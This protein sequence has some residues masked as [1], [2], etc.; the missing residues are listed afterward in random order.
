MGIFDGILLCSDWDGTLHTKEGFN[1]KDLKAIRYFKDNG[2]TF[3]ICSGRYLPYLGS[4]FDV[5]CP[6]TYVITLNGAIIIEPKTEA[7]A[8]E[9]FLG[10]GALTILDKLLEADFSSLMI[11]FE[12]AESGQAFTKE[13]YKTARKT[14]QD[15]RIYK[16]ILVGNDISVVRRAKDSL[17]GVDLMGHT[18]VSS[19]PESL[20]LISERNTKGA[21]V[22]RLKK[23]L[24]AR[25]LVTVGDYENDVSMLKAADIGYAMGDAVKGAKMAA[26]RIT[27]P[28]GEGAIAKIISDLEAEFSKSAAK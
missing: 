13:E 23:L 9:G 3:T 10:E 14:I 21:A 2:G 27:L 24:G 4:F 20:E 17:K 22:I 11:Y 26:D 1:E 28:S 12:N 16:C 6:N 15:R 5:I 7:V 25:V 19:W 8:Y 18:V